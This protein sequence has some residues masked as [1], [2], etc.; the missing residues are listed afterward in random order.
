MKKIYELKNQRAELLDAAEKAL[1][2]KDMETYQSKMEEVEDL[3][4][5]IQALENLDAEQN[6]FGGITGI[7]G[8]TGGTIDRDDKEYKDAFF[9]AITNGITPK[10]GRNDEK[11]AVL[12]NAL[13]ES[14]VTPVGADGGF[15]VP[16]SFNNTIIECRRQLVAL[17]DL[18]T[19]ET[20]STPTGWR[21]IDVNPTAGFTKVDEMG[22]IPK[23]D[24]P[25]FTKVTYSL[26]KYGLI[27]PVSSELLNDNTAGL[28]AYLARWFARKGI[29]TENKK[30][31]GILDTLTAKNL[32]VGKEVK[33][34]TSVLNK[35]LD[36]AIAAS[37]S[38]ITNQSGFDYLCSLEDKNE[39]TLIQPDPTTGQP[40]MFRSHRVMV[41][42]DKELPNRTVTTT[43]STKGDYYP[44]YIGAFKEFVTLFMGKSLEV[45]STNIGGS[46]W[47]TDSVEVRGIM[48]M[49]G[50]KI[51][52]DAAVKR[53]IFVAATA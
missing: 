15:L 17:S 2:A 53:E 36:P 11:V 9:Y 14:G 25:K 22:N 43:G 41:L 4:K 16:T 38:I 29:I 24:Q 34:L 7:P 50:Q 35:E 33:A 6:R 27:V 39:R 52:G 51:D 19:V 1:D 47:T 40:M 3:N 20:V 18:V 49:D 32:T 45:A 13:T 30:I 44:L 12:Y 21:A 26:E 48:R 23:D 31:L 37:A 42:S 8:V 5:Q 46:A 10:N 28:E